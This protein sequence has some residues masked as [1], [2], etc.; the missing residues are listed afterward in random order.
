MAAKLFQEICQAKYEISLYV[1]P[2]HFMVNEVFN[3]DVEFDR[4]IIHR[5]SGPDNNIAYENAMV[6]KKVHSHFSPTVAML[7]IGCEP[8][9]FLLV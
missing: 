2:K 6:D 5:L 9:A 4:V 8:H 3:L 7:S 1:D